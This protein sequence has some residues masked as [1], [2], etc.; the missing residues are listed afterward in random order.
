MGRQ[1]I[2]F[3]HGA[4]ISKHVRETGMEKIRLSLN[5][6]F[7]REK[8]FTRNGSDAM[9]LLEGALSEAVDYHITATTTTDNEHK[10]LTDVVVA[11]LD[12]MKDKQGFFVLIKHF[13]SNVSNATGV[14]VPAIIAAAKQNAGSASTG[15]MFSVRISTRTTSAV[16]ASDAMDIDDT[17][18]SEIQGNSA[19]ASNGSAS[20]PTWAPRCNVSFQQPAPLSHDELAPIQ[21]DH[22]YLGEMSYELRQ[23]GLIFL[24]DQ[25]ERMQR[26]VSPRYGLLLHKDALVKLTHDIESNVLHSI[27]SEV[28]LLSSLPN[29]EWL[30]QKYEIVVRVEHAALGDEQRFL[31]RARDKEMVNAEETSVPV[32]TSSADGP[33]TEEELNTIQPLSTPPSLNGFSYDKRV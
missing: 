6:I 2:A 33:L 9:D 32:Q 16:P 7:L 19:S 20:G 31:A 13:V 5:S 18:A 1:S 29:K 17:G 24:H 25:L 30:D 8:I 27:Y 26:Q 11:E 15:V 10:R 22:Q 4:T 12:N 21:S 28:M 14:P 3:V 23:Y